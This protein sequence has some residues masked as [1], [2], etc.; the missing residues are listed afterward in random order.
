M[1]KRIILKKEDYDSKQNFMD[2]NW[3]DENDEVVRQN[4]LL[5]RRN[6]VQSNVSLLIIKV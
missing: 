3:E 6:S 4:A 5:L 1:W 2:G